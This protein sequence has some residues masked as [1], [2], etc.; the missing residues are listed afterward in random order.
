VHR[1][2]SCLLTMKVPVKDIAPRQGESFLP[3][4]PFRFMIRF[5]I[6]HFGFLKVITAP[7]LRRSDR[8]FVPPYLALF[9]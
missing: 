3:R 6:V 7:R 4:S 2:T 9:S 5:V 1:V 8:S